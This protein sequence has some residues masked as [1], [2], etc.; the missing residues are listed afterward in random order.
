MSLIYT[1]LSRTRCILPS[2]IVGD[3]SHAIGWPIHSSAYLYIQCTFL[4]LVTNDAQSVLQAAVFNCC[5]ERPLLK[6]DHRESQCPNKTTVNSFF[7][8]ICL[9]TT[10][11]LTIIP[12]PLGFR[13]SQCVLPTSHLICSFQFST[14]QVVYFPF[15]IGNTQ[16]RISCILGSFSEQNQTQDVHN[17]WVLSAAFWLYHH[18][19]LRGQ[20][21][22]IALRELT[23]WGYQVHWTWGRGWGIMRVIFIVSRYFPFVGLAMTVYCECSPP[24]VDPSFCWCPVDSLDRVHSR[25]NRK[26]FAIHH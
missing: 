12:I 18:F 7:N 13:L 3:G 8:S 1:E 6:T 15:S 9:L 23:T 16:N 24:F 4:A 21:F 5:G 14:L 10:W 19:W 11:I 2:W 22:S 25:R 17:H 20:L 26:H